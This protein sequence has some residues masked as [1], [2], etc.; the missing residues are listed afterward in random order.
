[1]IREK[2]KKLNVCLK[3]WNVDIFGSVNR[4]VGKCVKE[5]NKVDASLTRCNAEDEDHL[6]MIRSKAS[7]ELWKK[8]SLKENLLIQKSRLKWLR[9]GDCNNKYLHAVVKMRNI[10]KFMVLSKIQMGNC[11]R[12]EGGE[13]GY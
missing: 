6:V 8:L 13:I 7:S 2:L 4:E 12:S 11:R 9:G 5:I 3:K 1:M 10:S